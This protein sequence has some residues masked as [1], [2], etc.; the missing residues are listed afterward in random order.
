MVSEIIYTEG[1]SR[2]ETLY[3]LVVQIHC[4]CMRYR[5]QVRF[6]YVAGMRMIGQG[7]DGLSRGSF[8]KGVMNGK[9]MLLFLL[10]RESELNR[11]ETLV[12]CIDT[13]DYYLGR[14][15]DTLN[16]EG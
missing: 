4:L 11:L 15:I 1:S 6:I 12:R 3:D 8:Y 16:L 9:T 13:W 2:A 7:T 10:L 14:S 5:C